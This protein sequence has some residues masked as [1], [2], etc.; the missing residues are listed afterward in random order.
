M[1]MVEPESP[2]SLRTWYLDFFL[3]C[4]QF[5][6]TLHIYKDST[7]TRHIGLDFNMIKF[8]FNIFFKYIH[9]RPAHS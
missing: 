7:Y 4:T 2:A 5:H 6:P 9:K 1:P 8:D 3:F